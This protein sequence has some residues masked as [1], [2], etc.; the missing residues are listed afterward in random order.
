MRPGADVLLQDLFVVARD[1]VYRKEIGSVH[2]SQTAAV[3]A[4]KKY[5]RAEC[6]DYHC[7]LVLRFQLDAV[8]ET[9]QHLA[10]RRTTPLCD[11]AALVARVTRDDGSGG[12]L[13]RYG[14]T[15]QRRAFEQSVFVELWEDGVRSSSSEEPL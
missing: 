5:V 3:E 6:D 15:Q 9:G 4:A 11:D 8:A 10:E 7:Y 1:G 2:S 12:R 13:Q 14:I